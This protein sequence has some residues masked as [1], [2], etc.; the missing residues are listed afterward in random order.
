MPDAGDLPHFS[1][2]RFLKKS[3]ILPPAF[4]KQPSPAPQKKLSHLRKLLKMHRVSEK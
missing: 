1:D 3:L 2:K 4:E